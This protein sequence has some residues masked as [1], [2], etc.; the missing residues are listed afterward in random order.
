[1]LPK[2]SKSVRH[3]CNLQLATTYIGFLLRS[4]YLSVDDK[5][6]KIGLQ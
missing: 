5:L 6:L 3:G 1:M 2:Y 4:I